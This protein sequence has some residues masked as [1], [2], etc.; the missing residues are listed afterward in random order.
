LLGRK[1]RSPKPKG[2]QREW[3]KNRKRVGNGRAQRGKKKSFPVRGWRKPKASK[4]GRG[5]KRRG[6]TQFG[7][8]QEVCTKKTD[9]TD[10]ASSVE[11]S[12]KGGVGTIKWRLWDER[13]EK[14]AN[15]ET[16]AIRG[17]ICAR[18]KKQIEEVT[19]P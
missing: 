19:R 17:T 13:K 18:E 5:Q 3:K 11:L 4:K 15:G 16:R 12:N 9:R 2:E 8:E 1:N 6:Q 7:R 10:G 14:S